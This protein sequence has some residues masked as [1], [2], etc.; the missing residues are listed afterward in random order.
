LSHNLR[1]IWATVNAPS[2]ETIYSTSHIT[3]KK[4]AAGSCEVK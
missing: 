2:A 1:G 4:G 3:V